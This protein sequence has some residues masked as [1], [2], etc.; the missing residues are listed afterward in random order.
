VPRRSLLSAAERASLLAVP[1]ADDERIRH[2]ALSERDLSVI[3]L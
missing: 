2:F 3:R 1:S